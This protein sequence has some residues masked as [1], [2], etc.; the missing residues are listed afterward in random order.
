MI[1]LESQHIHKS[2]KHVMEHKV[3]FVISNRIF[4]G[5]VSLHG[6][7]RFSTHWWEHRLVSAYSPP[8]V[9]SSLY[10]SRSSLSCLPYQWDRSPVLRKDGDKKGFLIVQYSICTLLYNLIFL[11]HPRSKLLKTWNFVYIWSWLMVVLLLT[12]SFC[13]KSMEWFQNC[14]IPCS[15]VWPYI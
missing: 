3:D 11:N 2:D 10:S 7:G 15:T 14:Q 5:G 8:S 12:G 9:H 13:S 6:W 4:F 1:N